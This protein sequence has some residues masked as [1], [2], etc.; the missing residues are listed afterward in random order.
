MPRPKTKEKFLFV[1]LCTHDCCR[2]PTPSHIIWQTDILEESNKSTRAQLWTSSPWGMIIRWLVF[3]GKLSSTYGNNKS[4][5][6]HVKNKLP[7]TRNSFLPVLMSSSQG[8]KN[9]DHSSSLPAQEALWGPK[10]LTFFPSAKPGWLFNGWILSIWATEFKWRSHS[11][12][13][14]PS[15]NKGNNEMLCEVI[16]KWAALNWTPTSTLSTGCPLWFSF[17]WT[18]TWVNNRFHLGNPFC[19]K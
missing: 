19:K 8:H 2:V 1:M 3:Q 6:N 11:T 16:K 14:G 9:K 12:L 5:Q 13:G 10:E 18:L 4:N 15:H 7:F 17:G